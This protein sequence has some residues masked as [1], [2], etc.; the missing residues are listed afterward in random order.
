[1]DSCDA[2]S[3]L[4]PF[5]SSISPPLDIYGLGSMEQSFRIPGRVPLVLWF[6]SSPPLRSSGRRDLILEAFVGRARGLKHHRFFFHT[7][8]GADVLGLIGAVWE[9]FLG[10][11]FFR[12]AVPFQLPPLIWSPAGS[13]WEALLYIFY[14][15][16]RCLLKPH[17][18]TLLPPIPVLTL[19]D[20]R[21]RSFQSVKNHPPVSPQKES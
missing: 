6:S 19:R 21:Q 9:L 7:C 1:V 3:S 13:W 15:L 17:S 16:R 2:F 18:S 4:L 10:V 12:S 14:I 11:F 8:R 5:P 20:F